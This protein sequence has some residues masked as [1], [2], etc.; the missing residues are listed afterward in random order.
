LRRAL[1]QDNRD[2]IGQEKMWPLK[3]NSEEGK[4]EKE[5]EEE[6]EGNVQN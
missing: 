5:A 6:K 1:W 2:I 3:H 4:E